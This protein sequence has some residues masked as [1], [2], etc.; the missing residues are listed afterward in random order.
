MAVMLVANGQGLMAVISPS[1]N[2]DIIGNC[3]FSKKFERD[4]IFYFIESMVDFNFSLNLSG[5]VRAYKKAS[6]VRLITLS[7]FTSNSV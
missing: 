3:E 1:I 4:S 2:A 5:L 6:F 7:P